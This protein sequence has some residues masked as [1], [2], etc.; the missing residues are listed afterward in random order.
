MIKTT[1]KICLNSQ[2]TEFKLK[3][4]V[5]MADVNGQLDYKM[6][7]HLQTTRFIASIYLKVR[8]I[9]VY[10]NLLVLTKLTFISH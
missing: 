3:I 1:T 8:V 5:S 4:F 6:T 9:S 10:S 7:N 2:I